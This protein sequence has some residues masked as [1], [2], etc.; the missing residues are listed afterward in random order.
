MIKGLAAG[1]PH[2]VLLCD[3]GEVVSLGLNGQRAHTL[4]QECRLL[5]ERL[6]GERLESW[7][8]SKTAVM[9]LKHSYGVNPAVATYQVQ[10]SFAG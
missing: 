9:M 4:S 10:E 7:Q 5:Y 1:A 8:P 3:D 2:T 6:K